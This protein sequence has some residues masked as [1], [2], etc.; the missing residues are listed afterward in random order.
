MPRRPETQGAAHR[1]AAARRAARVAQQRNVVIAVVVD[2]AQRAQFDI[3][4][5]VGTWD[6]DQRPKQLQIAAKSASGGKCCQPVGP[7]TTHP[8]QKKCFEPIVAV[9]RRHYDA[10]AGFAHSIRK[11]GVTHIACCRLDSAATPL[12]FDMAGDQR[13]AHPCAL[14]FAM[15]EPR[16]S[17]AAQTVMNVNGNHAPYAS[18]ARRRQAR[19]QI[20]QCHRV[21]ATA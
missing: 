19:E 14:G 8:L 3:A 9:M 10:R 13:H 15:R 18:A 1:C 11:R 5:D 16:V 2:I 4:L 17:V 12:D 7:R 21:A 20:E 6:V